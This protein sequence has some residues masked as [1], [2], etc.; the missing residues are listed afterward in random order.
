MG[1]TGVGSWVTQQ[2]WW[3][4]LV[5]A[6]AMQEMYPLLRCPGRQREKVRDILAFP[7][8]LLFS[9][10]PMLPLKPNSPASL[11]TTI[12]RDQFLCDQ[13]REGGG[14]DLTHK[15][16]P[17][18]YG[19]TDPLLSNRELMELWKFWPI[20]LTTCCR[21]SFQQNVECDKP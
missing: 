5:R 14:M 4:C 1:V 11:V 15:Q 17:W 8:F 10:L 2:P 3:A 9:P 7:F 12:C 18:E 13:C 19:R 21:A 16:P 6:R 20:A